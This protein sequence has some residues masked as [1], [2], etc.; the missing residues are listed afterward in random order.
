MPVSA[1][2]GIDLGERRIGIATGDR[3]TGQV[4]TLTTLRRGTPERDAAA[5]GRLCDEHAIAAI[6]IGLP[7]HLDGSEGE[8]ALQTR[9]W[10]NSIGPLLAR[11]LSFRD[12]RLTSEA[13]ER[14]MG[15]PP[16]GRS[17][18]PPSPAA[19][20]AWRARV[21]REAAA[22]IVQAEL[23]ASASVSAVPS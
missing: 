12:E 13:A 16:R 5:I 18:G 4:T 19:R 10:A 8:Q 17:G 23:D 11:P 21:D 3:R 14:R 22:E 9:A 15:R 7:L 6:V 20:R 2:L 1:I